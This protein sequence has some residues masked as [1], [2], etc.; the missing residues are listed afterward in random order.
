MKKK[1]RE[2]QFSGNQSN[3]VLLNIPWLGGALVIIVGGS[4]QEGVLGR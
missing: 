3:H 4:S 1:K 2:Y